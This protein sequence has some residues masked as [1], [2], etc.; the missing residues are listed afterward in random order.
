MDDLFSFAKSTY[1]SHSEYAS[2]L[3]HSTLQSLTNVYFR[4]CHQHPYTYFHEGSFR[5]S[6]EIGNLPSYL[7]LAVAA[8]AVSYSDELC[9]A[10][11]QTEAMNSY[12]RL[13]WSQIM[14]QSFADNHGPSIHTVQAANMLGIVDYLGNRSFLAVL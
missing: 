7:M 6:L 12:S 3:N 4:H 8:L 10:G 13:A 11:H 9:F 1:F 5:Q 14:E 2:L